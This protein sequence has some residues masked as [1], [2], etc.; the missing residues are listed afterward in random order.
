MVA[1]RDVYHRASLD[2]SLFAADSNLELGPDWAFHIIDLKLHLVPIHQ[3]LAN[4]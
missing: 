2:W 4:C 1:Y 3:Y